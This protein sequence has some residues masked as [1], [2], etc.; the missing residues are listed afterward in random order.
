[1]FASL[2]V[3]K[4]AY[5]MARHAGHRQALVAEN[6]AHTDTPGYRPRDLADFAETLSASPSTLRATRPGHLFGAGDMSQARIVEMR[7]NNSPNGNAVSV[8]DQMLQAVEVKRQH[9]RALAIYKSSLTVLRTS[10]G[11]GA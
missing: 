1:M 7:E 8:E 11:R 9:D 2:E 6:M 5:A 10:L 3:M 4:T